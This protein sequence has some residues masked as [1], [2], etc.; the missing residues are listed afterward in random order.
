ML[1]RILIGSLTGGRLSFTKA[2][3]SHSLQDLIIWS[4]LSESA[5]K[6]FNIGGTFVAI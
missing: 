2:T 6:E 1:K 5:T 4:I 3:N